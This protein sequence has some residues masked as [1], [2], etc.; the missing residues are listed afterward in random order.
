MKRGAA[1]I[2]ILILLGVVVLFVLGGVQGVRL[3][4]MRETERVYRWTVT[5]AS[6]AAFGE[7]LEGQDTPDGAVEAL[8]DEIF[9]KLVALGENSLPD[10]PIEPQDVNP[11]GTTHPK[12]VRAVRQRQDTGVYDM[13]TGPQG[14]EIATEFLDAAKNDRIASIG[15]QFTTASLYDPDSHTEGVGLSSLFFGLR[16]VAANFLWMQVD[17]FWHAGQMHRMV[18]AMRTTV[19]LDPQFIDAYLLGAWHLAYNLTARL[20]DTPEPQ[21]Q[22]HPKYKRRVGP[23]EE[24]YYIAADFLKDGIRKNPRNYQLYFDLGYAIYENKLEDHPNAVLYLR[25]ARRYKHD[26]WV[27]RMLYLAMWRN[28]QYE[29]AI[30]GWL[31][32]LKM[33]PENISAQRFLQINRAY[34]AEAKS[35]QAAECAKAARAAIDE[36]NTEI[37]QARSVGDETKV[38]QAQVKIADAERVAAEMET[39]RDT[40]WQVALQIY[41]AMIRS[42]DD[43]IAKARVLRHTALDLAR[44]GRHL[45]AVM[46]LDLARYEMMESFDE[47]SNLRIEIKQQG[48]LPLEVTEQLAIE[49]QREAAMYA[50]PAREAPRRYVECAYTTE[51]AGP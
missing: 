24:W 4:D 9:A 26:K 36:F 40:E 25:E 42:S 7:S 49:R 14:R 23:K 10:L 15:T 43:T 33:D 27:P 41:E 11:D 51:V 34:L 18:P 21:K 3:D 47:L 8:D 38:E 37:A 39:M 30:E 32:Y 19:A 20:P 31:D 17:S 16:K 28:G 2:Q 12:L 13:L 48:G 44:Q 46:Q 5:A 50:E 35:E 22:F 29:D 6:F 1:P 45:E